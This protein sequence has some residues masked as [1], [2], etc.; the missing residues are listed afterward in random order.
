MPQYGR[1]RILIRCIHVTGPPDKTFWDIADAPNVRRRGSICHRS[2]KQAQL[3]LSRSALALLIHPVNVQSCRF[4]AP[5][6][7]ACIFLEQSVGHKQAIV[8]A[9]CTSTRM[10][11]MRIIFEHGDFGARLHS[12]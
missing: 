5:K 12:P 8:G 11:P 7:H 4:D 6:R 1:H 9:I 10:Y 2:R 3:G